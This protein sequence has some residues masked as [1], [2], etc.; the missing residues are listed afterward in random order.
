MENA[1]SHSVFSYSIHEQ[2]SKSKQDVA[3]SASSL[4][5]SG[6]SQSNLNSNTA[7]IS[8]TS[9]PTFNGTIRNERSR[10]ESSELTQSKASKRRSRTVT[11]FDSM[12][13][14]NASGVKDAHLNGS[15]NN[16]AM[17]DIF[18][19]DSEA[20]LSDAFEKERQP[21]GKLLQSQSFNENYFGRPSNQFEAEYRESTRKMNRFTS[22][23]DVNLLN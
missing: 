13:N 11:N 7:S 8:R 6:R 18:D 21:N 3:Q 14:E 5:K 23:V 16:K 19:G 12:E 2:S 20:L 9:L 4:K 1:E 22:A 15:K 10:N 17:L